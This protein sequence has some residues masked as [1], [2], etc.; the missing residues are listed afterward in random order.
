MR[1]EINACGAHVIID[2]EGTLDEVRTAAFVTWEMAVERYDAQQAAK[3][4]ERGTEGP[5]VGF[6]A[7]RRGVEAVDPMTMSTGFG[8]PLG[9]VIA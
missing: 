8:A 7:E 9:P 4:A 6:Q 1:I 5:A 2:G 3:R